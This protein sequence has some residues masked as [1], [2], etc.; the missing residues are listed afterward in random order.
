MRLGGVLHLPEL[1]NLNSVVFD[2]RIAF[3]ESGVESKDQKFRRRATA[4]EDVILPSIVGRYFDESSPMTVDFG[5]KSWIFMWSLD[6][7]RTRHAA[8][9]ARAVDYGA[10]SCGGGRLRRETSTR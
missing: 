2:M 10:G 9:H 1:W 8:P 6:L 5:R 4:E 3:E 7:R